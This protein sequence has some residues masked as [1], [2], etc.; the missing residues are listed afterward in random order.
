M[1]PTSRSWSGLALVAT[2]LAAC[3]TPDHPKAPP[4]PPPVAS[5][6]ERVV[7]LS[8]ANAGAGVTLE[9]AQELV[10]RLPIGATTGLEWSL[11]DL[12]PGVL[13]VQSARF[14]RALR[15]TNVDEAAGAAVWHFRPQASGAVTLSFE[16]RRPHSLQ[17]PSQTVSYDV[18]V[19]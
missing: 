18:T 1:T 6:G 9:S 13:A 8:D 19:K 16:L 3:A 5:P 7:T 14:E 2:L 15:N 11:G 4:A 10:V 17:A 12:K